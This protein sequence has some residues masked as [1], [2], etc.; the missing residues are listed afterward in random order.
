MR[1][2]PR[3]WAVWLV[4]GA[5][6]A[7]A[8]STTQLA[9]AQADPGNQVDDGASDAPA[10]QAAPDTAPT[11]AP[12]DSSVPRSGSVDQLLDSLPFAR[13]PLVGIG[14]LDPAP[15]TTLRHEACNQLDAIGALDRCPAAPSRLAADVSYDTGDRPMFII[16]LLDA[17]AT[18][19]P[20][21][22]GLDAGAGRDA[23]EGAVQ[24]VNG[25]AG[26]VRVRTSTRRPYEVPGTAVTRP[27]V[28]LCDTPRETGGVLRFGTC[29]AEA[30]S[31][32][33][34]LQPLPRGLTVR[35]RQAPAVPVPQPRP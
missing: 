20:I 2:T 6:L 29:Y 12:G 26:T 14:G 27:R 32:D 4:A 13:P 34:P 5:L 30:V 31:P 19:A 16:A 1:T 28:R 17:G 7:G 24:F 25:G 8:A 18:P 10:A 23:T 35:P 11:A 22:P 33:Y 9:V 21:E 15:G 3:W